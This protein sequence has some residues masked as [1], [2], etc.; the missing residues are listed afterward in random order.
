MASQGG[1]VYAVLKDELI[2]KQQSNGSPGEV[3]NGCT[4]RI[5]VAGDAGYHG[6]AVAE[7]RRLTALGSDPRLPTVRLYMLV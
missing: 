1:K 4:L 3:W 6:R 2:W 5:C 7:L